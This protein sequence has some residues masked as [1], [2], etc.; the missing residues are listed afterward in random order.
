MKRI[1]TEF[2]FALTNPGTEK[3][4]KREVETMGPGSRMTCPH[5]VVTRELE[6]RT[7]IH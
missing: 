4:L 2:L 6:P 7:I 1:E 3:A 5:L